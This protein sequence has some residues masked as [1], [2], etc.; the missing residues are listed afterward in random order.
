MTTQISTLL[1]AAAD[2]TVPV[3]RALPDEALT[4]PTPCEGYD[5][6]ELTRHLLQVVQ[7]FQVLAAKGD[8]DWSQAAPELTGDWRARFAAETAKL[9]AAWGEPGADQGVAG[10]MGM[11]AGTVGGMA[12]LDL[13][14]HG[15]DLAR[16]AGLP[17]EPA[18][19]AVAALG[20][21]VADLAPNARKTGVF[22]EPV[23]YAGDDPFEALLA[24]S[25]RDA[26]W[27]A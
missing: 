25:G 8:T 3:V 17:Y 21:L 27:T 11:P 2:R 10:A 23:D 7:N 5:V 4:G 16:A 13:T 19:E 1:Q 22:G 20:P 18:P 14:V 24:L 12:L 26:G 6:R 9:V 15:W